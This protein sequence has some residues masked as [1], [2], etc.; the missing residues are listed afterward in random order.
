MKNKRFNIDYT[1]TGQRNPAS[2]IE[3]VYHTNEE[4]NLGTRTARS[5]YPP[6]LTV[7]RRKI[8]TDN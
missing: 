8:N 3:R 2:I 5:P 1:T 4:R 7:I 6:S